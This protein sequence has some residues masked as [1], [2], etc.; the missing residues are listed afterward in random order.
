MIV[1]VSNEFFN[2]YTG[3]I[4]PENK[5]KET[6]LKL[7]ILYGHL[8]LSEILKKMADMHKGI[9]KFDWNTILNQGVSSF[10]ENLQRIMYLGCLHVG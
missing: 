3:D 9:E 6:P 2:F 8:A 7:T 10:E 4:N 1:S 5:R